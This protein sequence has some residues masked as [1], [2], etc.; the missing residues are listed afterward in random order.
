MTIRLLCLLLLAALP[1]RAVDTSL[2][3]ESGPL[4]AEEEGRRFRV[5]EGFAVQL[6]AA[7]PQVN[8][9]INM[10]F[11]GRG[12]LWV[13]SSYEYP[14]AAARERWEDAEGTRVKGSRDGIFILE[15]RDGDGRAE[16]KTIFADGLNIP[17]GVLPYKNGCIA[18]SVP[19]ILFLEDVDGDGRCDRRRVLFGPLGWEK[20]VHGNC[21]SFRLGLDGWVYGTHGFNNSSHFQVRPENLRGAKAGDPGTELALHSGNVYRFLPDG[22]RIELFSAGQVNPFGLDWD[23]WG[24]LYSADCHSA[25]IYQLLPGAV[26]PSF[27]KP[28][29]GLGFGPLMMRHSH[30]STGICGLTY[31]RQGVWGPEW[32]EQ[33]LIGNVVTSRI[34][35]DRITFVGSQPVAH[36]EED[37]LTSEDPWFRPVDLRMGPEGALYVADFYNK[38]IGHYEVPLEHPG[39]DKERGRIWRVVKRSGAVG[40]VGPQGAVAELRFAARAGAL[41]AAQVAQVGTFLDSEEAQERRVAVEALRRPL[42]V[43]WIPRLLGLLERTPEADAGMRHQLRIVLREHLRL[44]GAVG[45]LAGATWSA[46][47]QGELLTVARAAGTL[48][49]GRY[50]LEMLRREPGLVADVGAALTQLAREVPVAELLALIDEKY[51]GEAGRQAD[52]LLAVVE[53]LQQRGELPPPQVLA[54]GSALAE[55][56]LQVS[57]AGAE[58]TWRHRPLVPATAS[59]WGVEVRSLEGGGEGAVLSSLGTHAEEAGGTLQSRAFV[60]PG[61]LTFGLCGHDGAPEGAAAGLNLVR[62]VDA[63]SGEE[64]QRALVPRQDQVRRVIWD[65][66]AWEGRAAR[67]EVVDG[68]R[69]AAYAW[70]G[71]GAF[72]PPVLRAEAFAEEGAAAGRLAR[73]GGL[74]K[75]AAAPGLRER[76]A[77]FLPPPPPSPPSAVTPEQRAAADRLIAARA[78]AYAVAQVDRQRGAAVFKAQCAGCHAVGGQGALVGPQLDGIGNRGVARLCEDVLDPGRNVD[79]H[80]RLHVIKRGD[81]SLLAG[82]ERG[83]VGQVLMVVDSAGQE[84]RVPKADIKANEET[85]LSLMPAA[86][87]ESLPEQDFM[88]LMAWLLSQRSS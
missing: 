27:G 26:Y 48:E 40:P 37:F 34:N 79:S 59:P 8:K 83:E 43:E 18:W 75:Y 30:S 33:I 28:H 65:L 44:P 6:F 77:G 24:N 73:L 10:A 87:G 55:P 61:R 84:H 31:L 49:A 52:L 42:G 41:T 4:D 9:P 78:A 1:G 74:L 54:R 71:V 45:P 56:L 58:P 11:D 80:F 25:P 12:R 57:A 82:L 13:S 88:D 67:L 53:G 14:Y 38:V 15:D 47:T 72:D 20:D 23:S 17:T 19:N 60:V 29:D 81:D 70:L 46:A 32:N 50:V 16:H 36:E 76:L 35:R 85:A 2:V 63:A 68:H 5:P 21:S 69:G 7:E 51:A 22:S 62:L 3:R 86:F 66:R 39:R 64:W